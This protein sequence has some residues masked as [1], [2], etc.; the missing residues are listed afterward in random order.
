MTHSCFLCRSVFLIALCACALSGPSLSSVVA[1]PTESNSSGVDLSKADKS[2]AEVGPIEIAP[3]DTYLRDKDGK[4]IAIP[5]FSFEEYTQFL[6]RNKKSPEDDFPQPYTIEEIIVDG[7]AES[8]SAILHVQLQVRIHDDQWL[9]IPLGMQDARLRGK[10]QY[11]TDEKIMSPEPFVDLDNRASGFSCRLKGEV[12]QQVSLKLSFIQ[13]ITQIGSESR[14][15]F[16]LPRCPHSHLEF[17]IPA[18]DIVV[19]VSEQSLLESVEEGSDGFTEIRALDIGGPLSLTWHPREGESTL[20]ASVLTATGNILV[21]V[22][23][24]GKITSAAWLR[25]RCFGHPVDTAR[26]ELPP[27][28]RLRPSNHDD[29]THQGYTTSI[30]AS[31]NGNAGLIQR[32]VVEIQFNEKATRLPEVYLSTELD[33]EPGR[34]DDA[35][36]VAGFNVVGAVRQLGRIALASSPDTYPEWTLDNAS[37]RRIDEKL[38]E[39]LQH[40][41]VVA[42]FEYFRQPCSLKLHVRPRQSRVSVEPTYVIKVMSDRVEVN[43]SFDV[44]IRGSELSFFTV[45]MAGWEVDDI[46]PEGLVNPPT[47]D[48]VS[49]LIISFKKPTTG[50]VKLI[51]RGVQRLPS[52]TDQIAL[53]LP[54]PIDVKALRMAEVVVQ[55]DDNVHLKPRFDDIRRLVINP[56]PLPPLNQT[57]GRRQPFHFRGVG[58]KGSLMFVADMEVEKQSVTAAANSEIYVHKSDLRI[59]QRFEYQIRQEPMSRLSLKLHPD[60]AEPEA[61]DIQLDGQPVNYEVSDRHTD[62]KE[63]NRIEAYISLPNLQHGT[64]RLEVE[65]RW[66]LPLATANQSVQLAVPLTLPGLDKLTGHRLQLT[67]EPPM[68]IRANDS[69]WSTHKTNSDSQDTYLNKHFSDDGT[70]TEINVT[71][72]HT[73]SSE[74][75]STFV[76]MAWIQTWLSRNQ[77]IER[78]TFQ[79]STSKDHV[80]LML[81]PSVKENLITQV[82][83]QSVQIRW[84]STKGRRSTQVFVPLL[85]TE[86]T[87]LIDLWYTM[88]DAR[89]ALGAMQLELPYVG[90]EC[91]TKRTYWQLVTPSDDCLFENPKRLDPESNWGWNFRTVDVTS[92]ITSNLEKQFGSTWQSPGRISSSANEYWFSSLEILKRVDIRTVGQSFLLLTFGGGTLVVGLL[93][94]YFSVLRHPAI[95]LVAACG[96]AIT[97]IRYPESVMMASQASILGIVFVVVGRLFLWFLLWRKRQEQIVYGGSASSV[98]RL[99]ND[100]YGQSLS[101][102]A[103]VSAAIAPNGVSDS[104]PEVHR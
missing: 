100:Q 35:I 85:G 65:Y 24:Q 97:A 91:R 1:Q 40:R 53:E 32:Q 43:A 71:I 4:L 68:E 18:R 80:E 9:R 103:T 17:R 58:E 79:L 46:G 90:S 92:D 41:E 44:A 81:P 55:P 12:D 93:L 67:S 10:L 82:N 88:A 47:L 11:T 52:G 69:R 99:Q 45:N 72:G 51:V 89:P 37:V 86:T 75:R 60:L 34:Y 49:P 96:L 70:A 22:E 94:T 38:P 28:T 63:D 77:R 21:R 13:P 20:N 59:K 64:C 84:Q 5:D 102:G 27:N 73:A 61:L 66:P 39:P 31:E 26:I 6:R 8:G 76:E 98:E 29:Y 78:A 16:S 74:G 30:I 54:Q 57:S 42:G 19:N 36:E 50:H 15:E 104:H 23:G 3:I 33:L 83:G 87:Y 2:R 48:S 101:E 7:F 95:L 62:S 14:V 56:E 25:L